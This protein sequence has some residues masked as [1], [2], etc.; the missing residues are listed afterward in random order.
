MCH[1]MKNNKNKRLQIRISESEYSYFM[2]LKDKNINI[3]SHI[4]S[5]VKTTHFYKNYNYLLNG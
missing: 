2:Y 5:L 1:A 3:S 4:L